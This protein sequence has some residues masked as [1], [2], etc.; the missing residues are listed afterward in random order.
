M[1]FINLFLAK[2][3]DSFK[4]KSPSVALFLMAVLGT[5]I[6]FLSTEYAQQ[7][8]GETGQK[9]S[10][11]VA[12]ILGLLQGSRTADYLYVKKDGKQG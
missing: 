2:I 10:Y 7:V 6:T 5:A 11:Y 4:A 1:E 8:L 12:L 9:I 3:I